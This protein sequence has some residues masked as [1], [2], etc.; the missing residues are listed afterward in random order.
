MRQETELNHFMGEFFWI[1]RMV[2]LGA[3][4]LGAEVVV[5][6][7]VGSVRRFFF[8]SGMSKSHAGFSMLEKGEY[9]YLL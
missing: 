8:C 4:F 6:V 3:G 9:V 7:L 2:V 5:G 1:S